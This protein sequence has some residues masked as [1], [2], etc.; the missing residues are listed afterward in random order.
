[1]NF[2]LSIACRIPWIAR[3]DTHMKEVLRGST[4]AASLKMLGMG[5]GF[6]YNMLL[7]RLLGAEGVG[8]YYLALSV[9]S[10]AVVVSRLGLDNVL[11]RFTAANAAQ[12]DWEKIAGVYRKGI[13]IA[14]GASAVVSAIVFSSAF[15][16]ADNFYSEPALTRPL[17]L[18]AI[19]I[20]PM[21]LLV[22]HAELLKGLKKIRD[23]TLINS[24]GV[25]LVSIP[26]L[27][28]LRDLLGVLGA[29]T[30]YVVATVLVF[31]VGINLWRRATP[32][33][34]GVRGDFD[35][36]SL[37]ATAFP[38][39][40]VALMN[41]IMKQI[42]ILLLG[43]WSE[44]EMVGIYGIVMRTAALTSSFIPMAIVSIAAPK[45][46][47]L[48]AEGDHHALEAFARNVVMLGVPIAAF[49]VLPFVIA[50]SWVLG[51]FGSD[52]S[53]GATALVILAMG[54]FVNVATGPVGFLLIMTGYEKAQ[55]NNVIVG[56]CL[57]VLLS[58]ILIPRCGIIGAAIAASVSSTFRNI[59][60]VLLVRKC[61][62]INV[63]SIR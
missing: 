8:I 48:Y 55:R 26:L 51:F 50:P 30:A 49:V 41:L 56:V 63:W 27:L 36:H 21:S 35:T 38:L 31:F 40:V 57:N 4:V 16:I 3:L 62:S 61:L 6:G 29:V 5:L 34:R 13:L 28:L 58:V 9:T 23:A 54:E 32:Q 10:I 33:I 20:L 45:F 59:N 22:L 46:A 18:M 25:P 44:S 42:N 11:L 15:W 52:F 24:V 12:G 43:I 14:A 37:V 39:F 53:I 60:A 19:A 7:A 47:E 17:Q 2:I 1:M